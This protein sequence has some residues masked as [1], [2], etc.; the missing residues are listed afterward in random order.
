MALLQKRKETEAM[1]ARRE[2]KSVSLRKLEK[3]AMRKYN[4][5]RKSLFF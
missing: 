2:A 4:E 5:E 3:V 1:K